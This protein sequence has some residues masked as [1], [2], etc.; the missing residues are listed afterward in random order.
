MISRSGDEDMPLGSASSGTVFVT[1]PGRGD[2]D[3]GRFTDQGDGI[4][5]RSVVRAMRE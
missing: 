3:A 5:L 2:E 4:A 1:I